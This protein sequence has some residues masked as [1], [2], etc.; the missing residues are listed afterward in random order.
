[1]RNLYLKFAERR[2]A[3]AQSLLDFGSQKCEA[4]LSTWQRTKG[5]DLAY[6]LSEASQQQ[7]SPFS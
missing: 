2:E 4:F 7:I 5:A 3:N 6:F 1:L